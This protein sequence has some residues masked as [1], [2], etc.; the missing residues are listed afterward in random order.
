MN[1]PMPAAA[2]SGSAEAQLRCCGCQAIQ[3]DPQPDFRCAECGELL[4]VTY[5]AWERSGRGAW[6]ADLKRVWSERRSSLSLLDGSGVWRYREL[7]PIVPD[8]EK[9]VTLAY[10]PPP[11]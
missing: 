8:M 5:P 9:V 1:R 4:E 11:A 3:D 6:A 2:A 7:L 10:C